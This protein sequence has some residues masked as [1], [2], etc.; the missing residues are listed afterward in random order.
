MGRQNRVVVVGV[1]VV[2][3]VVVVVFFFSTESVFNS[4]VCSGCR[5]V[6]ILIDLCI[7]IE[8][9]LLLQS[10]S[11]RP[12]VMELLKHPKYSF[13]FYQYMFDQSVPSVCYLHCSSF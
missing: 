3:V 1:V 13:L 7:F 9:W 8:I 4:P 6:G 11:R 10:L 2:G 5:R 12:S